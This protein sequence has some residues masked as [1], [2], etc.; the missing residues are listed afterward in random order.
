MITVETA[1]I[2]GADGEIWTLPRPARHHTVIAAMVEAG[3]KTPIR[4]EQGFILSDGRFAPRKAALRIAK[5]ANQIKKKCGC[6]GL[7]FSEDIW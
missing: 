7:L 2:I 3:E 1:A 6:E 4:G 5:K